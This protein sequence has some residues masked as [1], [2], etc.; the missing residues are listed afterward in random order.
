MCTPTLEG[1]GGKLVY[2]LEENQNVFCFFKIILANNCLTTFFILDAKKAFFARDWAVF[3]R[4]VLKKGICT[5]Q[6]HKLVLF[7]YLRPNW[8]TIH[9]FSLLF[10][11]FVV[12][13]KGWIVE[14]WWFFF[15]NHFSFHIFT[16]VFFS[17]A[18]MGFFWLLKIHLISFQLISFLS[19]CFFGVV[20]SLFTK[21]CTTEIMNAMRWWNAFLNFCFFF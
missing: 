20:Q 15:S 13:K 10:I 8:I 3:W 7:K 9:F 4:V 21:L 14:W 11:F 2:L 12:S 16:T 18:V 5:F 17:V 19:F 6:V 1:K